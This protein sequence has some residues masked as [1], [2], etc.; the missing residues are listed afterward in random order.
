L[1]RDLSFKGVGLFLS[2]PMARASQF[3]I[4]MPRHDGAPMAILCVALFC[5]S[6]ADGLYNV[7]ATF[8]RQYDI[9]ALSG[10][11]NTADGQLHPANAAASSCAPGT[12]R[13]DAELRRIQQ[14]I[15]G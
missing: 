1:T 5:H 3:I 6:P 7:G 4:V 12:S 9:S 14:S 11:D 10:Y 2:R 8:I 13:G 15:L